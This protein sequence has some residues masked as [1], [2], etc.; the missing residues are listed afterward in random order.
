[1]QLPVA[2][3]DGNDIAGIR[4]PEIQAPVGTHTGWSLRKEGVGTG[5]FFSLSGSFV[6]FART[7][8]EREANNDPRPSIEERYSS[9]EDY[10]QR[11]K[12]AAEALVGEGL[13]LGED[14]ARYVTAAKKRNPLDPNVP[15]APLV[16]GID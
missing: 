1:L 15:L 8:A 5:D 9:H 2:D 10:V 13:M 16:L 6:P 11:I 4:T 14:A 12:S 3:D 7:K